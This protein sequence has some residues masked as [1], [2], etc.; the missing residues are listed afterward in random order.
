[1]LKYKTLWSNGELVQHANLV[2]WTPNMTKI[3]EQILYLDYIISLNDA[4]VDQRPTR[5][6]CT[7]IRS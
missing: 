3:T 7:E 6:V 4:E 5:T 2:P 1:M